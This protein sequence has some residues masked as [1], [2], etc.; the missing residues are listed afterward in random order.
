[1]SMDP[2]FTSKH[3]GYWKE[4]SASPQITAEF[5]R[6][7]ALPKEERE[8]WLRE[9][10]TR[11]LS[12]AESIARRKLIYCMCRKRDAVNRRRKAVAVQLGKYNPIVGGYNTCG[13]G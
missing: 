4:C 5:K 7:M 1:M 3:E 2:Y 10:H 12:Y 8:Q 9:S 13:G 6:L 11:E